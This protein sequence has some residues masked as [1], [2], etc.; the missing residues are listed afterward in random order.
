MD[1]HEIDY[2]IKGHDVQFVEIELDPQETVIAEA[3]AMLYMEDGIDFE[4]KMGDGS[5]PSQGF[6]GKIM[7]GASRVIT[8]ESLFLTHFTHRGYGK[9]KV[10]FSAPY[11]GTIV[12]LNLP[13]LGGRVIVQ[14]DAFLCAALGTKLSMHFNQRLG[15]GFFGGEG[16]IL[17][18]LEGDGKAFIHAGG[19]LIERHL[20][21]E[22]LRIDTGCVVGFTDGI[23]FSV[24]K[25][26]NLKSMIFG[27][28]GLFLST[29]RGTG[30]VWIQSMPIS[31]LI[32]AVSPYGKN[33]GKEESGGLLNNIFE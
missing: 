23:D 8:G 11:P 5:N 1:S 2:E 17:Q 12:P 25:A 32:R 27:G 18:K 15:A 26:G 31:K 19:T 4:A 29:L 28:E 7:A 3:G 22:S 20:N 6:F 21:N 10:A 13:Q 30:T 33:S 14:K 9:K 16:F 24:Q